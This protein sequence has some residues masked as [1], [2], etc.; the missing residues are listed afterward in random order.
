MLAPL[1]I[2]LCLSLLHSVC[3]LRILGL[4]PHLGK[5][6]FDVFEPLL[7][8]LAIKGHNVTVV[9]HFPLKTPLKNYEDISLNYGISGMEFIDMDQIPGLK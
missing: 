4:F 5:S 8:E 7:K 1:R 3:S 6:H 2:L 9:S